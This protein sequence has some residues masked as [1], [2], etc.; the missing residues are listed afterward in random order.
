MF[1][2]MHSDGPG[3]CRLDR[4]LILRVETVITVSTAVV[5]VQRVAAKIF[6][7]R[8]R[9]DVAFGLADISGEP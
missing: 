3:C 7:N 2:R 1:G 9:V 8:D 6:P 4:W 5:G